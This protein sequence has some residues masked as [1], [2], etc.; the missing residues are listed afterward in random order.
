MLRKLRY[1]FILTNMLL[2]S[3]VLLGVFSGLLWYNAKWLEKE[4]LS[5]MRAAMEWEEGDPARFELD[6][7]PVRE[8]Q[9]DVLEK[10]QLAMLS[11]F[12]VEV[13][14]TGEILS[15]HSLDSVSVSEELMEQA[16]SAA[17]ADGQ[18]SGTLESLHLRYLVRT[19]QDGS[20]SMAFLDRGWEWSTT[21]GL[22]LVAL[23]VG[24]VALLCF[25]LVSFFLST[26]ALRPV[27][28]AWE[29]QRQFVADASHE[30]KTPITVI[31][32]NAGLLMAHPDDTVA[33][34]KK[35]ITFIQE[36]GTRM[37]GLVED[38][39]FLA[40]N[41]AARQNGP[42][43]R[44][45]MSE[46]V[47]GCVLPFEPVAFE[48]GV[49]LESDIE[50]E[51]SLDGDESQLKRLVLILLDNAVKYAGK[52]GKVC[53]TLRKSQDRL[54]LS[55]RNSGN[56]IPPEHL[57]HIFERFYRADSARSREQGGYGLG[58]AIAK[59]I[60][61]SHRGRITAES[62]AVQGTV[63]TAVLPTERKKDWVDLFC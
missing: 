1:R 18:S 38:M 52:G 63:F 47:T 62:D 10:R 60:V 54:A 42:M 30:L 27:S 3:L 56:P 29:Q 51:L 39:L 43:T 50:P 53:V 24:I 36:E 11:V 37:R 33:N 49:A 25:F 40:K 9:E 14:E 23:P 41:D 32:A 19:R 61:Q 13:D 59:A 2:V 22:I 35:W 6:V 12:A 17:L 44:L 48:A 31:L 46:L 16:V 20:K 5:T 34:Q 21:L 45:S 58:L 7:P 26:L 55:V 57:P 28:Q 15:C 4:S 8:Q